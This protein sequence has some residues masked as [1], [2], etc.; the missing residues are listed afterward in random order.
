MRPA[1]RPSRRP[2]PAPRA[3]AAWAWVSALAVVV[4][5]F[6]NVGRLAHYLVVAHT[7]CAHGELVDGHGHALVD[8]HAGEAPEEHARAHAEPASGPAHDDA[9]EHCDVASV[10][11]SL[12]APPVP[13]AEATLLLLGRG[14]LSGERSAY[15]P[16]TPLTLAPKASPPRS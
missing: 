11:H 6:A 1:R 14:D 13:V 5:L 16:T 9:H 2:S 3:R 15:A 10:C 7:V 4:S 8:V 12:I